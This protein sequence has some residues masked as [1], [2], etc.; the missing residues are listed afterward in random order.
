MNAC[1]QQTHAVL[2]VPAPTLWDPTT[3]DVILAL[4]LLPLDSEMAKIAFNSLTFVEPASG[5]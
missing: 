1:Q 5:P 2:M 3:V 4:R